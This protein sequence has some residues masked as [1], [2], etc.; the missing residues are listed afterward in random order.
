M[1]KSLRSIIYILLIIM[2]SSFSLYGCKN[3]KTDKKTEEVIDLNTVLTPDEMKEDFDYLVKTLKNVHPKTI[4]G[5]SIEQN[6]I[7]NKVYEKIENPMTAE[8]FFFLFHELVI[9]FEDGHT[10]T[11]LGKTNGYLNV[12]VEWL[13]GG[14]Y[15]VED[16]DILKK[17]DKIVSI[18]GKDEDELLGIFKKIISPENVFWVKAI[19]KYFFFQASYLRHFGL[20]NND[21]IM[22]LDIERDGVIHSVNIPVIEKL[23]RTD[24]ENA[25]D[26]VGWNIEEDS[27]LA[28]IYFDKCVYDDEV[29]DILRNFFKA[30]S[31]NGIENIALDLRKNSGGR[32]ELV[33]QFLKYLDV[34]KYYTLTSSIRYS[35]EMKE[36][37]YYEKDS[38]YV[39]NERKIRTNKK[40]EDSSLLFS[41]NVYV[42]TSFKTFSSANWFSLIIKDNNI[43][44][45]IGE[46]TGNAT[47]R[48]GDSPMFTMPNTGFAFQVSHKKFIRP[49]IDKGYENA[50]YPNIYVYTTIDD[51]L[52]NRDPQLDKLKEIIQK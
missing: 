1:N 42:L 43:G 18:S 17:G 38:G 10:F 33:K 30:V 51:I 44:K 9:S 24:N 34:E 37:G 32:T 27:N 4:D 47:T 2:L 29:D 36:F 22:S 35:K 15:I 45:I 39:E 16:T 41:G 25:R 50:I 21:D 13:N 5:F 12:P 28:V 20:I 46:P 7:I 48:F 23:P 8:E 31:D 26:W 6:S 52:T 14:I 11:Q 49:D 40:I 19:S 3:I